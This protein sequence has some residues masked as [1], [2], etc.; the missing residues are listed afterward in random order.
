M[1]LK[2]ARDQNKMAEFIKEHE[3][4]FPPADKKRFEK[5][6]KIVASGIAQ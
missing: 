3:G 5:L 2:Q 6:V 4:K 1:N